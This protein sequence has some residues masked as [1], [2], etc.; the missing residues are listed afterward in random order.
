MKDKEGLIIDRLFDSV[1]NLEVIGKIERFK[2]QGE[3]GVVSANTRDGRFEREEAAFLNGGRDFGSKTGGAGSFVRDEESTGSRDRISD[4][5]NVPRK[6]RAQI[7]QFARDAE[8]SLGHIDS[9]A[10]NVHLSTPSNDSQITALAPH[11][12]DTEL[13]LE[14]AQGD[15]L[16]NVRRTIEPLGLEEDDGIVASGSS[17]EQT[18]GIA[19]SAGHDH[20]EPRGVAKVGLRGLAVI[21]S[22]VPHSSTGRADDELACVEDASAAVP[23]LGDFVDDLVEG[24]EDVVRKLDLR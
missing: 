17:D 23:V 21:H 13:L 22:A 5:V 16:G 18:L 3:R 2:N 20:N 11:F 14:I 1:K 9:L 19:R 7:D 8:F 12:G 4:S 24:R 15:G 6:Q 10:E